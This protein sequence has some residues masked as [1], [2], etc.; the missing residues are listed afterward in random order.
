MALSGPRLSRFSGEGDAVQKEV[1]LADAEPV[2]MS[3]GKL[4]LLR[5]R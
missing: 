4:L 1:L 5:A 2:C 3:E